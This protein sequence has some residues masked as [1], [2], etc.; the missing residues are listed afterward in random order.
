M[1]NLSSFIKIC[2]GCA[3][4]FRMIFR[5]S[6]YIFMYLLMHSA[7]AYICRYINKYLLYLFTWVFAACIFRHCSKLCVVVAVARLAVVFYCSVVNRR[8]YI[9]VLCTY[10]VRLNICTFAFCQ[11]S[12]ICE[13][14]GLKP[15]W[16][17]MSIVCGK[18][19]GIL[20]RKWTGLE[21]TLAI[22]LRRSQGAIANRWITLISIHTIYAYTAFEYITLFLYFSVF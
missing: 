9:Y 2:F 18:M 16:C 8:A 7:C 21:S 6:I 22:K 5:V 13:W 12:Q 14:T 15:K 17:G 11:S 1:G 3:Q 19:I 4:V 20:G 10:Y